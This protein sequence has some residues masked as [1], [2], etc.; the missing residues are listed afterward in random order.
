MRIWSFFNTRSIEKTIPFVDFSPFLKQS[1]ILFIVVTLMKGL[2]F[3]LLTVS[4]QVVAI[5]LME[6]I[7]GLK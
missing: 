5:R 6:L 2:A 3:M 1:F 7:S 4:M